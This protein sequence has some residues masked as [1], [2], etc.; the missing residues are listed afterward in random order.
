MQR[1]AITPF[2]LYRLIIQQDPY[3][4]NDVEADLPDS[5]LQLGTDVHSA[6]KVGLSLGW[7][8]TYVFA[9]TLNEARTWHL[10]GFGGTIIGIDWLTGMMKPDG[11]GFLNPTGVV[12]GGHCVQTTAWND[13]A[14]YKGKRVPAIR[15]Q[16][17]WGRSWG[18]NGRAWMLADDF[19]AL[20][21]AET[22][23]VCAATELRVK[24]A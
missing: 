8:K 2:D 10:G 16:N 15:I 22:G 17:S 1:I 20:A 11:D 6:A 9:K 13:H 23:E 3:P 5:Q 24:A 19:A 18:E 7:F 4:D 21:F 14:V 12:E